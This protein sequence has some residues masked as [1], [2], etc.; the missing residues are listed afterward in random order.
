MLDSHSV[1]A[2]S[3]TCLSTVARLTLMRHF[4]LQRWYLALVASRGPFGGHGEEGT[5]TFDE[6]AWNFGWWSRLSRAEGRV[7]E[8]AALCNLTRGSS[9]P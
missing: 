2:N 1:P 9:K 4:G 6:K 3:R 7:V 5:L 8:S